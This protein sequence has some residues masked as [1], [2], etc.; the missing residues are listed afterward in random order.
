MKSKCCHSIDMDI[1]DEGSE[2]EG[3]CS[4]FSIS[5]DFEKKKLLDRIASITPE[6]VRKCFIY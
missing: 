1:R 4:V 5:T 2:Y 6:V 3:E